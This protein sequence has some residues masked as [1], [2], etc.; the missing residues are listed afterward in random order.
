MARPAIGDRLIVVDIVDEH[1]DDGGFTVVQDQDGLRWTIGV[2][3][4]VPPILSD[5][6]AEVVDQWA[7]RLSATS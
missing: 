2:R 1:D 6:A 3:A 4:A 5:A 7:A